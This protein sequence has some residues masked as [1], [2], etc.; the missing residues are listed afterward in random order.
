[1]GHDARSGRRRYQRDGIQSCHCGSI[2]VEG[3]LEGVSGWQAE[4]VCDFVL[5]FLVVAVAVAV[6]GMSM[7]VVEAGVV[8][9]CER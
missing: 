4:E 8:G 7:V 1:M 5:L 2:V 3:L 6:A 9:V